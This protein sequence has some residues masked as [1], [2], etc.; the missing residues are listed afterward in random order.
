MARFAIPAVYLFLLVH[1]GAY[2]H[3]ATLL[4]NTP[5]T[6]RKYDGFIDDERLLGEAQVLCSNLQTFLAKTLIRTRRT[7]NAGSSNGSYQPIGAP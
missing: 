2:A 4:N 7:G 1:P 3:A 6:V 5:E